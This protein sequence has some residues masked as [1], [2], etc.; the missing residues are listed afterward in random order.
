[1]ANGRTAIDGLSV[2]APSGVFG[3]AALAGAGQGSCT[4]LVETDAEHADRPREILD[5][6]LAKILERHAEPVPGL[7]ADR[8]RDADAAGLGELLQAR[9][10]VHAIAED[11]VVLA[12]HVAEVDADAKAD[13]APR[14]HVAV[15]P[16]HAPLD[17]DRTRHGIRDARELDQHA[18]AGG[19]DQPP[20]VLGDRRVDQLETMGLETRERARLIGFHQAAVSDHV[21][22]EDGREPA[23][24]CGLVHEPNLAGDSGDD[25]PPEPNPA[26]PACGCDLLSTTKGAA[27]HDALRGGAILVP[28]TETDRSALNPWDF[29]GFWPVISPRTVAEQRL[30]A[31]LERLGSLDAAI[32][33][34]ATAQSVLPDAEVAGRFDRPSR[35]LKNWAVSAV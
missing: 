33:C 4:V 3:R 22:R 2:T 32:L 10:H 29:C 23:F 9:G 26:L 1:M 28:R 19:L 25:K 13:L 21:G 18:I 6:L 15:A 30:G 31:V 35:L 24:D 5:A 7:I 8:A 16:R 11:V 17:L 14:R 27:R 20:L 12:D 34:L